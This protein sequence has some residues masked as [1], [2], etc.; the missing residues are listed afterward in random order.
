M[1]FIDPSPAF[2]SKVTFK[3]NVSDT[4]PVIIKGLD[5]DRVI[6]NYSDG[7]IRKELT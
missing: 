4:P 6:I 1:V 3:I 7:L 5:A 2:Y